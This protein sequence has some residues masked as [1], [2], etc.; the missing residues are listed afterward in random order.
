MQD[1]LAVLKK[2]QIAFPYDEGTLTGWRVQVSS[3]AVR[4]GAGML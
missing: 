2:L 3:G 1:A 4:A